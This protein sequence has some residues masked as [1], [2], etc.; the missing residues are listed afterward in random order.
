MYT[1]EGGLLHTGQCSYSGFEVFMPAG[2]KNA[3]AG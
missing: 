1:A 2:M 3:G